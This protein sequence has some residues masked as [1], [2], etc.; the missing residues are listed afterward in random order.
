VILPCI[1]QLDITDA[2]LAG[3]DRAHS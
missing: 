1:A 3:L 2:I